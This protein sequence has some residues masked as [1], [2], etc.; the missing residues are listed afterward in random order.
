[1]SPFRPERV[2]TASTPVPKLSPKIVLE[3]AAEFS[4]SSPAGTTGEASTL[5][6][7]R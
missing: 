1:M 4:S 3:N 7:V 2:V 6:I 5:L